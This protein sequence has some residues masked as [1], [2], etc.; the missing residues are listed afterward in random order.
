MIDLSRYVGLPYAPGGRGPEAFDC[1]GLAR[2]VYADLLGLALPALDGT[3][4]LAP[5]VHGWTEAPGP[6]LL[7]VAH[8]PGASGG[9]CGVYAGGGFVLHAHAAHGAALLS[10]L[11]GLTTP[12]KPVWWRRVCETNAQPGSGSP[13]NRVRAGCGGARA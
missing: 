2:L 8:W 12:S 1:W 11:G 3:E 6:R 5:E 10:R 9:H 4:P 7:D 13:A